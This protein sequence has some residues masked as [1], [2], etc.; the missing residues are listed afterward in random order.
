MTDTMTKACAACL[1]TIDASATRCPSCTQR[2]PDT[3]LSRDVQGRVLGGVCAALAQHFNWDVTLMRIV[4]VSSLA[5][6]GG[7]VFWVYLA[8]WLMT[9]FAKNERAPMARFFDAV[10]NVFSPPRSQPQSVSSGE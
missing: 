8:T 2:Q 3:G 6:T 10:G 1:T 4:F 5:V 9:P 7:L